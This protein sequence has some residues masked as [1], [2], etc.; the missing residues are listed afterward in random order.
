MTRIVAGAAGGRS[1]AVPPGVGTRPTSD[2]VR[3][4]VFSAL[5]HRLAADWA[6]TSVLDCFAGSGAMALEAVSRGAC[7]ALL[8]E[9]DKRAAAVA[10]RNAE[11]V[12]Q[13]TE[14][15]HE[16]ARPQV[17]V[18]TVDA[19]RL[20][21]RDVI[22][23]W[24]PPVGLVV[25]DPP[26]GDADDRVSDLLRRLGA[27]RWLASKAV[28]VVERSSRSS[29]GWPEGWVPDTRRRY[30]DTLICL[31]FSVKSALLVSP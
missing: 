6:D 17:R 8:I 10:R 31:G 1:L 16:G 18:A 22:A 14:G 21:D 2:R 7:A 3:E 11:V 15:A 28:A 26:Y 13:A 9:R 27:G 23:P 20:P 29:F 24:L 5:D 25:L 19:W 30:G 4:A 12:L